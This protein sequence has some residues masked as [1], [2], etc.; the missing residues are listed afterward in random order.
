MMKH[1]IDVIKLGIIGCTEST[2]RVL[3]SINK[4]P[5][6]SVRILITLNENAGKSKSRFKKIDI[7]DK[8]DDLQ[9]IEIS[10]FDGKELENYLKNIGLDVLFEIGWSLKIPKHILDM[11][12]FGTVGVHNSLLPAFQGPASLNWA[13]IWDYK[14]WGCT[15]FYLEENFDDGDII[16]QRTF[17]I[18]DADDIN[19]LFVK[20]DRVASEMV[21][22][23]INDVKSGKVPRR[24]QDKSLVTKTNKRTPRDSMINWQKSS[25]SIFNLVRA[26]KS[27]YP[28]AFSFL[29]G[30][31]F[32]I[33]N[34]V[35]VEDIKGVPGTV[36][37]SENYGI[38]IATGSGAIEVTEYK[39]ENGKTYQPSVGE[40]LDDRV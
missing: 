25:R 14:I 19:T 28:N 38:V 15:L 8:S 23:F 37:K 22:K 29:D 33:N 10:D 40:R 27:P 35:V 31:K 32:F 30:E 16:Y 6:L 12:T 7:E 5:N 11:P 36:L 24:A 9:V 13:L 21:N 2:E 4:V 20:S 17:K 3:N 18:D 34:S 26:T 39:F 1:K